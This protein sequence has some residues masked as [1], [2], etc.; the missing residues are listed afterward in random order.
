[1]NSPLTGGCACGAVR[2]ESSAEPLV[3]LQC[4]CRD[5][6]RA[7]GGPFASYVVVPAG[8]F[9]LTHGHPA[10][11]LTESLA[12]GMQSVDSVR[13]VVHASPLEKA[14]TACRRWWRS[15]WP[16]WTTRAPFARKWM[17]GFQTPCPG[18]S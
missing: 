14:L 7:S 8:A 6:Q 15:I 9:N 12:M 2:F 4:H 17:S 18:L 1:M 11:H 16:V 5:C 3:S 10:Y 13:S